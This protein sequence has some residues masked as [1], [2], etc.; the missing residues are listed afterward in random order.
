MLCLYHSPYPTPQAMR[1]ALRYLDKSKSDDRDTN[2]AAVQNRINLTE[3]F[4]M[5]R[6]LITSNPQQAISICNE[7]LMCVG[8]DAADVDSGVRIGDV[9]AL[10][11]E[12]WYE[13]RNPQ[14]AYKLVEQMRGRGIIVNPYLDARM[15]EDI[16]KVRR[17]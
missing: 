12:Y 8:G 2:I 17:L 16:Y 7:I 1:E 10:M 5:A 13:Q 14:E 15:V 9:Y 3:R 11:V 4:V 6:Q